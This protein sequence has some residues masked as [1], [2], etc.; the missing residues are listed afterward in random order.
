MYIKARIWIRTTF[1]AGSRPTMRQ[2]SQWVADG[3]VPGKYFGSELFI[4]DSFATTARDG[5]KRRKIDLLG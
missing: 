5:V 4:A 1:A 3:E 2:V